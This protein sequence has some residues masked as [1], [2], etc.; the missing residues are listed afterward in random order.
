MS[1]SPP[2]HSHQIMAAPWKN[3]K[4]IIRILAHIDQNYNHLPFF[5]NIKHRHTG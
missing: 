1:L 5:L 2:Y 3:T 4:Q